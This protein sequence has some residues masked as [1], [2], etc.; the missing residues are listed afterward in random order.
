MDILKTS[1]A[2]ESQII[3]DA[4][5]KARRILESADKECAAIRA[6][7]ERAAKEQVDGRQ[8]GIDGQIAGLRQELT[9]SLPLDFMRTRLAFIQQTVDHSL[10]E[11]FDKLPGAELARVIGKMLGRAA[12]AFKDAH[13]IVS[14]AGMSADE[15]KRVVAASVPG[16]T[17]ESVTQLPA[18]AAKAA[19]KGIILQTSD[20]GRRYRG[21]LNEMRNLLMEE[22]REELVAALLGKDVSL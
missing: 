4:R 16:V 13:V 17:I 8:A 7:A 21:T 15:A 22:Y 20:K 14:F 6:E 5:A 2:L 3:E 11:L 18:D 19:G 9:A 12:F 10:Q 1:D